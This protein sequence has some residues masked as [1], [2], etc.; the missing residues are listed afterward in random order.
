MLS[1]GC[2]QDLWFA[3]TVHQVLFAIDSGHEGNNISVTALTAAINFVKVANMQM[4]IIAGRETLEEKVKS[5]NTGLNL[6]FTH[7]YAICISISVIR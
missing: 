1:K 4:I 2:G 6:L 5:K 3:A 7:K